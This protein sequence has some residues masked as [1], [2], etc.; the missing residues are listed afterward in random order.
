MPAKEVHPHR[1]A[2]MQMLSPGSTNS[3]PAECLNSQTTAKSASMSGLAIIDTGAS[4]SV[5]G[6]D[7]VPAVLESCQATFEEWFENSPPT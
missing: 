7:L 6:N 3:E 2:A 1:N 4:R 5:L